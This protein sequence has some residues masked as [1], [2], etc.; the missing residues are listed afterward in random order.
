MLCIENGNTCIIPHRYYEFDRMFKFNYF[1]PFNKIN[2]TGHYLAQFGIVPF[3]PDSERDLFM[4]KMS[5]VTSICILL[6]AGVCFAAPVSGRLN[7]TLTPSV[8][9]GASIVD[10]W[11][12]YP[13]SD[14]FQTISD[15]SV[16]GNYDTSAVY[17][18]PGSG[19]VYLYA[20]W[21]NATSPRC[22]MSFHVAHKD[23]RN[24][25]LKD[26]GKE[27]PELVLPYLV[28]TEFI[29]ANDPEMKQI[30]EK[31]VKDKKGTLAKARAIYDWVVENTFRDPEVKACG[32]GLPVRT[33]KQC[34]GGGKCAD[35]SAVFV[36]LARAAGVP[37]RDVY[38]LRL[39][40]PKDGDVTSGF[41]CW[42]EFY[43]PGTGWVMVDPA[44]VRKMML[45][46]KLELKDADDWRTFFWGGDNLFRV[47]LE[48]NS[49]G[50]AL[51]GLKQPIN[52]FMY[53]AAQVDGS[54]LDYF[55]AA[56]FTYAVTFKQD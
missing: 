40:S 39:A 8:G 25:H 12:P 44:D 28:A 27:Y 16:T 49:R 4:N 56:A 42:A 13:M 15:M 2:G 21:K 52:Y 17:R 36:T 53:P 3:S 14:E 54:L 7:L 26:S 24:P 1:L 50:V 45:V 19:A 41:H 30:A 9:E 29:P 11:V 18:D 55:D 10:L 47:V 38:G 22:E 43:L 34:K 31:A 37:A 46:H 6:F 51:N 35:L 23:R 20:T 5:A 32:L 33:I 48:K